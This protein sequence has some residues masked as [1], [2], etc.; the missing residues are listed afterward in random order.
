VAKVVFSE[1][2]PAR[3]EERLSTRF[4]VVRARDEA[5]VAEALTNADALLPL[6]TLRV[7]ETLLA[8]APR[9]RIVANMAVGTDNVDVDACTRRGILVTNTPNVLTEATADLAFALLLAVARRIPEAD[10]FVRAGA[11]RGWAPDLLLGSDLS[12]KTLGIVGLGRIGHAVARRA[13]GFGMRVVYAAPRTVSG[14]DY[15]R[16]PLEELLARAEV[17]SLH[18][19]L[20][21]ETHHLVG[22]RE[23]ARLPRG[24]ILINTA[25]GAL[26]DTSALVAWLADGGRAGL[27]VFEDEPRV[28]DALVASERVVLSPHIGSATVETRARMADLA[29]EAIEEA[30]AGR[31][32][33][34]VVNRRALGLL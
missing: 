9:L 27:D 3:A 7:G 30:L 19:P 21:P 28:E 13:D 12:G 15:E 29:A 32:P 31:T 2:V 24:A 8:R 18:C 33:A 17:L 6:L 22:S 26:V 23:L 34:H 5:A 14:V 10:R 25:R 20:V 16:L 11:W 4:Q 1:G